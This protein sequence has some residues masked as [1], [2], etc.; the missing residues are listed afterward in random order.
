[1]SLIFVCC[2]PFFV[3]TTKSK[4]RDVVVVLEMSASMR[5]D[6]FVQAKHATLTVMETL[7]IQDRVRSGQYV[8]TH[9]FCMSD[10]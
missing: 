5:G 9:L 3:S 1:M 7:S 10:C 6:K 8:V 2:R 4:P